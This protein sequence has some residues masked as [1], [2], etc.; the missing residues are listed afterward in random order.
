[1]HGS[2]HACSRARRRLSHGGGTAPPADEPRI[3]QGGAATADAGDEAAAL[4]S[5][6]TTPDKDLDLAWLDA[7]TPADL[8]GEQAKLQPFPSRKPLRRRLL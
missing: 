7:V 8:R 4:H 6:V 2:M 5:T 1:M 3:P